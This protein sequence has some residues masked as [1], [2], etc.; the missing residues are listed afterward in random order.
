MKI[1]AD[2]NIPYVEE[3]FS[4]V[5][6]V[7][8]AEG[9]EISAGL[10][11]DADV[12]LVRS[13]TGVGR[14]LLQGSSVRFVGT[15]TIGVD[16]IDQEYLKAMGIG[17]ASA[18]GSNANSVAEY[19]IAA[20]LEVGAKKGIGLDGSS[21]GIVG[22]GNVGSRVESRAKSI[23]MEVVLNDPP[24]KRQTGDKKYRDI[25]DVY[26]CDFVTIHVPLSYEGIDKTYH[27]AGEKFFSKLKKGSV[28]I[29][30][31]RGAV[32]ETSCLKKAIVAGRFGGCVL[33]VWE[34][35]PGIDEELLQVVDIGTAHIAGYSF[36]G[37]VNGMIMMQER[38]AD[39]G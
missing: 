15:A 27:M 20:M 13:V 33:D 12:L 34:N 24:L 16:H 32:V 18:P 5:G 36:D 11:R 1:I 17:F 26:G 38:N 6:E 3:C 10:V 21:I 23:G 31:S 8:L 19:V 37:K 25:E 39:N 28:F 2:T 4:S 22:V 30:T 7:V 35:E 14:D 29:N 9:R